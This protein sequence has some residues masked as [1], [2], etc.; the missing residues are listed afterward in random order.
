MEYAKKLILCT[1]LICNQVFADCPTNVQPIKKGDVATCDGF[2]FTKDA[3]KTAASD[4]DDAIYYKKL[5]DKLQE[6]SDLDD[7]QSKILNNRLKL[8]INE[9]QSLAKS[10]AQKDNT[11][12]LY[13]F[14]YFVVGVLVT[15]VIAVN[16]RR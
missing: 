5:S 12:T 10:S 2:L 11:E 6:K 15:G 8:Y 16:V 13:R 14:G 1:A 4:R 3:E 9:S 7:Q